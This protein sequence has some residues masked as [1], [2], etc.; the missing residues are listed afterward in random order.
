[1][2]ASASV[3]GV[4]LVLVAPTS[5]QTRADPTDPPFH[6]LVED[7]KT[8]QMDAVDCFARSASAAYAMCA[9]VTELAILEGAKGFERYD[10]CAGEAKRHVAVPYDQA[11]VQISAN[12]EAAALL[13][14][15][16]A[17]WLTAMGDLMPHYEE[18]KLNYRRR[19]AQQRETLEHKLNRLKLEK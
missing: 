15:A 3:L 17:Y 2:T 11:R 1:M 10:R 18:V 4:M 5:A 7:C 19:L 6:L 9:L 12:K 16:Y 14:D 13:K 8:K